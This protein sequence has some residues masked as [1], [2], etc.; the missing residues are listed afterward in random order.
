MSCRMRIIWKSAPPPLLLLPNYFS[1][2][3]ISPSPLFLLLLYFSP[4]S[5]SPPPLFLL[6]LYFCSSSKSPSPPFLRASPSPTKSSS[7]LR[8][9]ISPALIRLWRSRG[10]KVVNA[11]MEEPGGGRRR[12]ILDKSFY[13]LTTNC[14]GKEKFRHQN[15]LHC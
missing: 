11:R 3:S 6:F 15:C 1:S 5:I 14:C 9:E 2:S 10:W 8:T 13:L 7:L 4:S 12:R